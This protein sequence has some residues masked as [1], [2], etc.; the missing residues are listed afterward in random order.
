M[1]YTGASFHLTVPEGK[2]TPVTES[3]LL[4]TDAHS[5]DRDIVYTVTSI[6][7]ASDRLVSEIFVCIRTFTW[8]TINSSFMYN[9]SVVFSSGKEL[10]CAVFF[11]G[12]QI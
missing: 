6:T 7:S 5:N 2:T 4:Y 11:C 12:I 8:F 9:F 10:N 1:F 3:E